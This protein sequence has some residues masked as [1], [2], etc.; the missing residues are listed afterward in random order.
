MWSV[1]HLM[2][3]LYAICVGSKILEVYEDRL[4]FKHVGGIAVAELKAPWDLASCEKNQL[5]YVSDVVDSQVWRVT[6]F[7][8]VKP[9]VVKGRGWPWTLSVTDDGL[10]VMVSEEPALRVYSS[11]GDVLQEISLPPGFNNPQH[12]IITPMSTFVVSHGRG[13]TELHRVCEVNASGQV[14]QEYGGLQGSAIGQLNWPHHIT[15]DGAG[16]IFVTDSN[17]HRVILLDSHCQHVRVIL[18]AEHYNI[19]WPHRLCF[20]KQTGQLI[21][22]LASGCFSIFSLTF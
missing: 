7:G 12:A 16:R 9:L 14:I 1:S 17:N 18:S 5:L 4:P 3:K 19:N 15:S 2:D 8:E 11:E 13:I 20:L 10:L 22:G 21:V 6:P